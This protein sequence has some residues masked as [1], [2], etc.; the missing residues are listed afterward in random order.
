MTENLT[1]LGHASFK[2]VSS[3][4]KIIYID[5]WQLTGDIV[6]ADIVLITHS[7][8]DHCSAEDIEKIRKDDT[9]I[10]GS[11]DCKGKIEWDVK[12][13]KPNKKVEEKGIVIE[14]VPAYN[15]YKNFHPKSNLWLGYIITVDGK[16]IYHA[17]DTDLIPEM[18]NIKADIMLV[19]VGGNYTMNAEEAAEAVNKVCP[20]LAIPMHFGDIVGSTKD[21][22]RFQTLCNVPVEIL[23]KPR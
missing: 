13:L 1:W 22:E 4:G 14:A 23:A 18:D 16:R 12:S 6:K 3:D 20:Q 7:H 15:V 9:V 17:G 21:A 8:H 11:Y 10:F 2:I 19:P 5:P